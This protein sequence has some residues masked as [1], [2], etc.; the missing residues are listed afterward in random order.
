MQVDE[1]LLA[2]LNSIGARTSI[3]S[4]VDVAMKGEGDGQ[5]K[6]HIGEVKYQTFGYLEPNVKSMII[7]VILTHREI[8]VGYV[9]LLRYLMYMLGIQN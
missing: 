2:S 5:E 8:R 1:D 3:A 4:F 9:K 7:I 6:E